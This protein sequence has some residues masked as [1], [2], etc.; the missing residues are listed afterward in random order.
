M[1]AVSEPESDSRERMV[2]VL[3]SLSSSSPIAN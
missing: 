1:Q 3:A 2:L